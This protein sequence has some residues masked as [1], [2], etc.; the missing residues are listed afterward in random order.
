MTVDI[1]TFY[2]LWFY[3]NKIRISGMR[4]D[5]CGF[6]QRALGDSLYEKYEKE[7]SLK[8]YNLWLVWQSENLAQFEDE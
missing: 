1:V 3:I 5:E 6:V 2:V 8:S 7:L 4:Q